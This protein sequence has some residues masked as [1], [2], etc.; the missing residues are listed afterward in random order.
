[1]ASTLF[2]S[3]VAGSLVM[4]SAVATAQSTRAPIQP[5][6]DT[7]LGTQGES[8]LQGESGRHGNRGGAMTAIIFGLIIVIIAIW[9]GGN[10][11]GDDGFTPIS[12]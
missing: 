5:A 10:K 1:M 8:E 7:A 6:A 4:S 3:L 9:I 2:K 12:P 11:N